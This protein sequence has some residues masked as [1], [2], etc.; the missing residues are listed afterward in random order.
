MKYESIIV[1][2]WSLY[3]S[4]VGGA[5]SCRAAAQDSFD[6]ARTCDVGEEYVDVACDCF[7]SN[8]VSAC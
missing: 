3:C 7:I 2:D 4:R 1:I 5:A 8:D 6:L